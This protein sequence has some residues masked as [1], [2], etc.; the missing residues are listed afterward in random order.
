MDSHAWDERYGGAEL[1]WSAG[2]NQFLVEE[3]PGPAPGGGRALDLACG[4]GRN[5]IWLAE[6][7]WQV[8][9]VDFSAAGLEKAARL[10]RARGVDVA[11]IRA[12][13]TRWEPPA[14]GFDLVAVFYLQLAGEDRTAALARACRAV[15]PGGT[16]L[17]VAHDADNLVRG[18]GGPQDVRVLYDVDEVAAMVAAGGLTVAKATQVE[19]AVTTPEGDRMALDVLVRAVRPGEAGSADGPREGA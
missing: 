16:L 14:T 11:W 6:Q 5:A 1:V 4:E 7:G 15:A 12:D 9:G 10:A 3:V 18:V 13:V 8:T 17:F 2:P 19:R